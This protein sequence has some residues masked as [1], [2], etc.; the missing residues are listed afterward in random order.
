M[1]VD[2]VVE[3]E[4]LATTLTD[5]DI[6]TVLPNVVLVRRWQRFESLITDI[7]GVKPLSIW[8][9]IPPHLSNPTTT[10]IP[11]QTH[12]LHLQVQVPAYEHPSSC[13]P[14]SWYSSWRWSS[15]WWSWSFCM[16]STW[17]G[18]W[19][20]W[21]TAD[22]MD[23]QHVFRQAGLFLRSSC[24]SGCNGLAME[25]TSKQELQGKETSGKRDKGE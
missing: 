2:A 23:H 6:A 14:W 15:I 20:L 25:R 11:S 21:G 9:L 5:K 13:A 8:C 16:P 3:V 22:S 24:L 4:L 18:I 1:S 17:P 12:P 7:T 19:L 10:W